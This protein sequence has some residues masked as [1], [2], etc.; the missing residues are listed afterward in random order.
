MHCLDKRLIYLKPGSYPDVFQSHDAFS[1]W[2]IETTHTVEQAIAR[3]RQDEAGVGV[4]QFDGESI[5]LANELVQALQL[6]KLDK[7][8][9]I[10]VL[11]PAISKLDEVRQLIRHHFYDY[12]TLPISPQRL[13]FTLGHALGMAVLDSKVEPTATASDNPMLGES[14]AMLRL[15]RDIRKMAAA[16]APV[17]ITGESGT[18]KELSAKAIHENSALAGEPFVVVNCGAIP[19]G[20]I[21]SELFGHEKGAFTGAHERHIGRFERANHGTLFL[22]EIA[23]LPLDMQVNLLRALQEKIIQRVGGR[24]DVHVEVRIVAATNVAL[25]KAV[26]EGRFRQDLYYRL[27]VL[28][29][30]L[31]P[32]RE[33]EGDV[34][35]IARALLNRFA[36]EQNKRVVGF[37]QLALRQLRSYQWPGNVRELSNRVRRAVVMCERRYITPTDLGLDL[38][39][40]GC[41]SMDAVRVE[42][43][44]KAILQSLQSTRYNVS[45]AARMLDVSRPKMYR[46]M[47]KYGISADAG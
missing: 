27:N 24:A 45:V 20:L 38:E 19:A 23:E 14:P 46:L 40:R 2:N 21:Q 1:D 13:S 30:H 31:P 32:L 4:V 10:A 36:R 25:E 33:R 16:D 28:N 18:G 41:R 15:F 11:D 9:W 47:Q 43:E 35:L 6:R 3:M 37:S 8:E 12:H 29:L 5:Y 44:R 26:A 34:D 42:V 39:E 22:D 7:L 17:L